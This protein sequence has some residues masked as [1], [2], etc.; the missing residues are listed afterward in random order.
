M[1]IKKATIPMK[2]Q[3]VKHSCKEKRSLSLHWD[4]EAIDLK[5]FW[6]HWTENG[7]GG[8]ASVQEIC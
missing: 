2:K 4:G 8:A 1:P 5:L 6:I 7:Y 3:P